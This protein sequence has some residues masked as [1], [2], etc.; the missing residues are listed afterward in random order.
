[1]PHEAFLHKF[2]DALPSGLIALSGEG[3]V[4]LWNSQAE[5]IT[6]LPRNEMIGVHRDSL[7][8]RIGELF[9]PAVC[10]M[11][12]ENPDGEY[13]YIRKTIREISLDNG[14]SSVFVVFTD[15]T[16]LVNQNLNMNYLLMEMA[17]TKDLMEEQAA[18]LAMALAEV[19][20]K[21]DIIQGQNRK[22]INELKMA[23]RLQKSLLPDIYENMNGVSISSKYIPSIHIGGDLYDVINLGQG[24]TGFVIADVSGHGVAA[25]LVS[26]MF[27]MSF[28][29]L[30]SNVASPKILFHMLNQELK[31]ILTEDYI[32]SFY[33]LADAVGGSITFTNASHP[34]PL[35]YRKR[36][37]EI[38]E[39][40]TEGFFLGMFDDGAYEEKTV[41]NIE[42]GDALLMYTDCLIETEN[43][44]AVPFGMDRLKK[45]FIRAVEETRGQEVIDRIEAEVRA[46]NAGKSF[47]DD[48]TVLLLEFWE[49]VD[50]SACDEA[51]GL[52]PDSGGFVEF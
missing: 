21:N 33:V 45:S 3:V 44:E 49:K 40:D 42:N 10:E 35:L 26:S 31:Q 50:V 6:S 28:N 5:D 11:T 43:S 18:R 47:S 17:E 38:V 39:L 4:F 24:L 46:Y 27:K 19:D 16:D 32:T 51:T 37:G 41:T 2:I 34:A 15:I 30:A 20:E 14:D 22:M 36:T 48:F 9:D 13:R 52:P 12:I 7:P 23:G 29:N 25:A 8:D 1:M